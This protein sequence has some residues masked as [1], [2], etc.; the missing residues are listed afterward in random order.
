MHQQ[1]SGF[2]IEMYKILIE[3]AWC[4]VHDHQSY[5]QNNEEEL[6]SWKQP[7]HEM[8]SITLLTYSH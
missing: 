4:I 5:D 6:C 7:V 3:C 8:F 2:R 1:R